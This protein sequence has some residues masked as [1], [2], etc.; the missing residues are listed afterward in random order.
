MWHWYTSIE[1]GR[2][3]RACLYP[4]VYA[5]MALAL[6]ITRLVAVA[7]ATNIE[8]A[9]PLLNGPGVISVL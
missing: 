7:T 8:A 2:M 6:T 5:W 3:G 9:M 4:K 1:T